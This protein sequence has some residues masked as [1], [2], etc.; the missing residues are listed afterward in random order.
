MVYIEHVCSLFYTKSDT[1]QYKA[2]AIF[3]VKCYV[4]QLFGIHVVTF[5]F[6]YFP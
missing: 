2:R 3:Q 1:E 5:G 6:T 4:T